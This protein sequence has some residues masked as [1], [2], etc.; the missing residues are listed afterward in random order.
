MKDSPVLVNEEPLTEVF[1]PTRLMHREGQLKQI[2]SYI[3]PAI[4]R[5]DARNVLV[6]GN[7]GTGKTSLVRWLLKEYFER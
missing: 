7:P 5:K 3:K 1:M 4:H 2:L 6:V